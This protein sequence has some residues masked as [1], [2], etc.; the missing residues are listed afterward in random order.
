MEKY[1]W[2]GQNFQRRKLSALW[3]RRYKIHKFLGCTNFRFWALKQ[4]VY[5]LLI[6]H[7][8][9]N[10]TQFKDKTTDIPTLMFCHWCSL[11]F[12][13]FMCVT[14]KFCVEQT[15]LSIPNTYSMPTFNNSLVITIKSNAKEHFEW[16]PCQCKRVTSKNISILFKDLLPYVGWGGAISTVTFYGLDGQGIELR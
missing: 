14:I 1:R 4:V 3:R 6:V 5:I 13:Y 11:T 9:V 2:E 16:P 12:I 8:R 7:C 10:V 15:N